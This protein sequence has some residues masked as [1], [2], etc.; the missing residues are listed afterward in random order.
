MHSFH[1]NIPN[2]LA[3]YLIPYTAKLSRG[4]TFAVVHKT[5][6]SLENFRGASGPCHYVLYT[7]N[8]SR[9]KLSRLAKKP[10]KFS[11]SKVLP[12]TVCH[13]LLDFNGFLCCY[14]LLSIMYLL[15]APKCFQN[16]QFWSGY[17]LAC[18]YW[19]AMPHRYYI[20]MQLGNICASSHKMYR[21]SD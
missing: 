13:Y 4:K 14:F 15:V 2:A 6:H 1:T 16:Y 21:L 19:V 18:D 17:T 8:D 3:T 7:A 12:Y 11:P 9:G 5:H 20:T 10:Q